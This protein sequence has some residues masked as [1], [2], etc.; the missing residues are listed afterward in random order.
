MTLKQLSLFLENRPGQLSHPCR[1]LAN[2]NINI[3]TLSLADTQQF[4]ILRLIV[5]DWEHAKKVLE[6][7]GCVVNVADV[8]AIDV[9]HRPG[10]MAELLEVFE[11]ENINIEYMYAFNFRRGTSAAVVIRF[12][13]P[14]A[15]VK[16][17]KAT[18]YVIIGSGELEK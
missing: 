7:A 2:N 5:R 1:V 4:G 12:D 13:D 14:E 18:G 6:E 16:L 10:G 15:A 17:L 11:Q 3:L 9:A 8:V